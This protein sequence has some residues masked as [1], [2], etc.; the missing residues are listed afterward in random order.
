[1]FFEME[2]YEYIRGYDGLEYFFTAKEIR[3]ILHKKRIDDPECRAYMDEEFLLKL[4][5][6][7]KDEPVLMTVT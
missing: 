3:E 4:E 7:E 2:D 1:M 5:A 6:A